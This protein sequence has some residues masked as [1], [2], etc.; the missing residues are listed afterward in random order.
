MEYHE[1]IKLAEEYNT[2][3]AHL[4]D[5]PNKIHGDAL[6]HTKYV[7]QMAYRVKHNHQ[8]YECFRNDCNNRGERIILFAALLHNI[9]AGR[10][11]PKNISLLYSLTYNKSSVNVEYA[12]KFLKEY[13]QFTPEEEK[14]ILWMVEESWH[15]TN[16]CYICPK[17]WIYE[18]IESNIFDNR[19]DLRKGILYLSVLCAAI[20]CADHKNDEYMGY[21][22][23]H[24]ALQYRDGYDSG[25]W[26]CPPMAIS[27]LYYTY[28]SGNEDIDCRVNNHILDLY[29][30]GQISSTDDTR[31]LAEEY[32]AQIMK[33]GE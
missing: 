31:E 6:E 27:D 20:E 4:K 33:E 28:D 8:Y 2:H 13:G 24:I 16:L 11:D 3:F 19:R 10:Y 29:R 25:Y 32:A 23:Y 17:E 15:H 22:I 9:G 5:I 1:V 12:K 18:Q 21:E 7:V 14:L 30:K 26:R